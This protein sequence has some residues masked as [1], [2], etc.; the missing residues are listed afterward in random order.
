MSCCP[1]S[2]SS[3][4]T[5]PSSL[6]PSLSSSVAHWSIPADASLSWS[7]KVAE[8]LGFSYLT[9]TR[10]SS[11]MRPVAAYICIGSQLNVFFLVSKVRLIKNFCSNLSLSL[12]FSLT[13]QI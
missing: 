6:G 1:S 4:S 13:F 12:N 8:F 3:N 5:S 11:S 9:G 10:T 2:S 7:T